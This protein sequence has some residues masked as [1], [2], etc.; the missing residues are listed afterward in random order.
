MRVL[1]VA[2]LAFAAAARADPLEAR[3]PDDALFVA[4]FDDLPASERRWRDS[5]WNALWRD[6]RLGSLLDGIAQVERAARRDWEAQGRAW[7]GAFRDGVAGAAVV[8]LVPGERAPQCVI[9]FETAPDADPEAIAAAL[10]RGRI[11]VRRDGHVTALAWDEAA[12]ASLRGRGSLLDSAQYRDLRESAG[13]GADVRLYLPRAALADLAAWSGGFGALR[14][15]PGFDRVEALGVAVRLRERG[16]EARA[17]LLAPG[18]KRG[19]LRFFDERNTELVP[20]HPLPARAQ[21]VCTVRFRLDRLGALL[22]ETAPG[23]LDALVRWTGGDAAIAAYRALGD[24]FTV[25]RFTERTPPVLIAGVDRPRTLARVLAAG[26]A[27]RAVDGRMLYTGRDGA[28]AIDG[29]R[30]LTASSPVLVEALLRWRGRALADEPAFRDALAQLPRERVLL[31]YDAPPYDPRDPWSLWTRC[32]AAA[33]V[34]TD[35]GFAL[36]Y[37]LRLR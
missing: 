19:V 3:L 2:L 17:D 20:P 5:D 12:L 34:N 32:Q 37:L 14:D 35:R 33:L 21:S 29:D 28:A 13:R 7:P 11:H 25:V 4:A 10:P 15:L 1:W 8:A 16:L 31:W 30:L 6:P 24:E 9:L 22:G 27:P 23:Q 26:G 18:G 36:H